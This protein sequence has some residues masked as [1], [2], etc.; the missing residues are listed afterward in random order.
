MKKVKLYRY[1][2]QTHFDGGCFPPYDHRC[3]EWS[4]NL[5]EQV[6][7]YNSASL[8][9]FEGGDIDD[10]KFENRFCLKKDFIF[11]WCMLHEIEVPLKDWEQAKSTGNYEYIPYIVNFDYKAIAER[12]IYLN[13]KNM[14]KKVFESIIYEPYKKTNKGKTGIFKPEK[15][16]YGKLNSMVKEVRHQ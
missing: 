7:L 2:G 3:T 10:W 5:Q 6:N 8:E 15:I 4:D 11:F 12:G 16:K 14:S 13:G 1:E 9:H